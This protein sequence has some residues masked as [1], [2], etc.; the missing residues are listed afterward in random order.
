MSNVT[1]NLLNIDKV[2]EEHHK[3]QAE[4]A[5]KKELHIKKI[6]NYCI[7]TIITCLILSIILIILIESTVTFNRTWYCVLVLWIPAL[8]FI[9][10]IRLQIFNISMYKRRIHNK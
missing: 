7:I 4:E 10:E 2:V 3:Q 1:T 5:C 9:K 6:K 8:L